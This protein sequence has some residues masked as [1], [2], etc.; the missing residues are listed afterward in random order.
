MWT[1]SNE[2]LETKKYLSQTERSRR[3]FLE[4]WKIKD[5]WNLEGFVWADEEKDLVWKNKTAL[6]GKLGSSLWMERWCQSKWS[7]E[8]SKLECSLKSID[9]TRCF[10]VSIGESNTLRLH[11]TLDKEAR[12]LPMTILPCHFPAPTCWFQAWYLRLRN[13][14]S[15]KGGLL[16]PCQD[17]FWSMETF[18]LAYNDWLQGCRGYVR[19]T[20]LSA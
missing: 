12:L 13:R 8:V 2:N 6:S 19:L 5:L 16:F 14:K 1:R 9:L 10:S 17:I 15:S 18:M 11:N 4:E 7:L 3:I 20:V